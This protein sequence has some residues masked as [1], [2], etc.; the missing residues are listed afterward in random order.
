MILLKRVVFKY[1]LAPKEWFLLCDIYVFHWGIM[2]ENQ[3][4]MSPT[5]MKV[6]R[7]I[8]VM[9]IPP[10]ALFDE[11]LISILNNSSISSTTLVIIIFQETSFWKN[12]YSLMTAG[13]LWRRCSSL[14]GLCI[15]SYVL[16]ICSGSFTA[17]FIKR[18]LTCSAELII[19]L[20]IVHIVRASGW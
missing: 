3:E 5:E 12:K 2:A 17:L 11:T 1:G 15:I 16:F 20:F 14:T 6:V 9:L 13:W 8:E 18:W 19:R 4:D 7:Q 10:F